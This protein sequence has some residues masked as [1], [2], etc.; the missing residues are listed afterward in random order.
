MVQNPQYIKRVISEFI[1][2][3]SLDIHLLRIEIFFS[4]FINV[5]NRLQAE[6]MA[7]NDS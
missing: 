4:R 6:E 3:Y 2:N 1:F 5:L 7:A